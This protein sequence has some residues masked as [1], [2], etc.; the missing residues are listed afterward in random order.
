MLWQYWGGSAWVNG[1]KYSYAYDGN[2]NL[3]EEIYQEGNGFVWENIFKYSHT[4]NGK[5]N[6]IESLYQ[7]WYG[8]AWLNGSKYLYSYDGNNNLTELLVQDWD[9]FDWVNEYKAI[10]SYIPTDVKEL[11]GEFNDY[12]LSNNFPNPFNP[13]T[14]I[15]FQISNPK[16]VSLKVYDVLGNKIATL[17]D[18]YK[19]AGSYEVA[20]DAGNLPSGIYFYKL[21]SGSFSKTLKMVLLK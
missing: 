8:S 6:K 21:Q 13:T 11:T 18:E 2:N 1:Q 19:T 15:R 4:Y 16:V 10:Y 20:F 17:V 12:S 9:G 7:N 3:I 5:N 14:T